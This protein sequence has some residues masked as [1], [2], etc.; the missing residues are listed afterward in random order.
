[1]CLQYKS[2]ENTV[3]KGE[4]ARN[5]QFCDLVLE[6]NGLSLYKFYIFIFPGFN[7]SSKTRAK[8]KSEKTIELLTFLAVGA[9]IFSSVT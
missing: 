6:K 7:Y 5:D 2:F 8:P 1:M 3:A 9:S 4:I